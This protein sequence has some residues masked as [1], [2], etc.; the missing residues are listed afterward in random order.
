L[1]R[2]LHLTDALDVTGKDVLR[3]FDGIL[4]VASYGFD[5]PT[6]GVTDVADRVADGAAEIIKEAYGV[7]SRGC[8][9]STIDCR[10]GRRFF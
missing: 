4:Q 8:A 10:I 2:L 9:T 3:D 7:I 5:D 1:R 6:N